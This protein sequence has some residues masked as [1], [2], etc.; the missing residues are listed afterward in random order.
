MD[1]IYLSENENDHKKTAERDILAK[2]YPTSLLLSYKHQN[3][4]KLEIYCC[5]RRYIDIK[6]Q[7]RREYSAAAAAAAVD[8]NND[9]DDDLSNSL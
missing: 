4:H 8:D 5:F 1:N 9:D 6:I 3:H 7:K 2:H